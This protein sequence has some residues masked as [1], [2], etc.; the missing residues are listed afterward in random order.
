MGTIFDVLGPIFALI[1]LGF[2]ARRKGWLGDEFWRPA[3][4]LT[5]FVL[6]PALLVMSGARANLAGEQALALA[7]AVGAATL[8]VAVLTL[9]LK[10]VLGLGGAGFTSVFQ[11]AIR[12]NT[13]VG[14]TVAF[15]LW[16]DA[17]LG[18][19][20]ICLLAMVPLV[21]LLSVT[22]LVV[23]G[24]G[25]EGARTPARAFREVVRNPLVIAC[26]VGFALNALDAALPAAV[27][28]FLDILG[29]AALP[30]SLMAVGAGLNFRHVADNTRAVAASGALKLLVLPA[31]AWTAGDA[32]G[33][34]GEA[35][36]MAV[37]YGALPTA[38][39]AYVLARQMGGDAPLMGGLITTATIA[40]LATLGGWI[41]VV[42]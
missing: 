12:P 19:I 14:V 5:Y 10:P 40:A 6:F 39:S 42:Q 2:A 13:F 32:L 34:T 41:L 38:A 11:G 25:H 15:L 4:R 17:G 26:A 37:L 1:A 23:W 7:G 36:G 21:N 3:E 33:L 24:D 18:L 31:L 30:L 9:T 8:G 16:G 22:V 29:R 28:S 27:G 20:S 35:L